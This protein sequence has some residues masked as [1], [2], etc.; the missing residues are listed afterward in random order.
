[1]EG[2]EARQVVQHFGRQPVACIC[3]ALLL[4]CSQGLEFWV[5][6]DLGSSFMVG[7]SLILDAHAPR[8]KLATQ[9]TKNYTFIFVGNTWARISNDVDMLE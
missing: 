3:P 7:P 6:K 9:K 1:M 2:D 4:P 8:T 5:F